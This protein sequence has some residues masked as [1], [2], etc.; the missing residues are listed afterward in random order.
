MRP[1]IYIQ[2][3]SSSRVLSSRRSR[4]SYKALLVQGAVSSVVA[5]LS[6]EVLSV[7]E[8]VN[9]AEQN[10]QHPVRNTGSITRQLVTSEASSVESQATLRG[11]D[12]LV[13]SAGKRTAVVLRV[14]R[15]VDVSARVLRKALSAIPGHI[16]DS[17]QSSVGGK[18]HVQVTTADDGVVGVLDD[19][20]ENAIGGRRS[21]GILSIAAV[22]AVAEDV[23]VSALHPVRV[24]GSVKRLLDIG[25]VE[26]DLGTRR[27]V[28]TLVDYAQLAVGV[29][30]CLGDVVNVETG[31]DLKNGRVEVVELIAS[32]GLGTVRIGEDRERTLWRRKLEVCVHVG[33]VVASILT[34]T[35]GFQERL[36]EIDQVLPELDVGQDDDLLLNCPIADDWVV[37]RDTSKVEIF[38]IVRRDETVG[39]VRDIV[40]T[41]ALACDVCLPVLGLESVDEALVEAAEF[42]G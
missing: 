39:N 17:K 32:A 23:D 14:V 3:E 9:L 40:T 36:V 1:E 12:T 24:E 41:V 22:V 29:R 37:D 31:V 7:A 35:C 13:T 42:G 6:S 27:R 34:L 26:V 18:K 19:T 5:T 33:R 25:A 21:R 30:A 16:L 2:R 28:V 11:P 15:H 20:L 8:V 10:L 4:D 38:V